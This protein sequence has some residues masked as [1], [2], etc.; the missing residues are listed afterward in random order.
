[1]LY[2]N[3]KVTTA[4]SLSCLWPGDKHGL[5]F[6]CLSYSPRSTGLHSRPNATD[7]VITPYKAPNRS[8]TKPVQFVNLPAHGASL[9]QLFPYTAKTN[10]TANDNCPSNKSVHTHTCEGKSSPTSSSVLAIYIHGHFYEGENEGQTREL[11]SNMGKGKK[12]HVCF[13]YYHKGISFSYPK[14]TIKS[15]RYAVNYND[16]CL[17]ACNSLIISC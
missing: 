10:I 1:M 2:M 7:T 13:V 5:C 17:F 11:L 8:C 6:S 3:K 15:Y 9:F 14:L 12:R 16:S 4:T